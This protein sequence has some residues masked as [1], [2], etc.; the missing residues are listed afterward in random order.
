MN[1][2]VKDFL[3][4]NPDSALDIM[5]PR[6]IVYVPSGYGPWL[7][8]DKC[9]NAVFKTNGSK[10]VILGTNLLEQ[11]IC[12]IVPY[13]KQNEYYFLLTNEAATLKAREYR[14]ATEYEQMT[15]SSIFPS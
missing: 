11:V 8:S 6:G 4:Q 10:E 14:P 7:L 12:K 9:K 13:R 3:K 5:T 15:F 2:T 1:V